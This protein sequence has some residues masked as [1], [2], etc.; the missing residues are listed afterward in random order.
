MSTA[1]SARRSS[2]EPWI[3]QPCSSPKAAARL[4]SRSVAA[5]SLISGCVRMSV[6]YCPAML[7][8]PTIPIPSGFMLERLGH[9]PPGVCRRGGYCGAVRPDQIALQLYTVRGLAATD[10]PGTLRAV[11]DAGYQ[12]V[13]L[14]GLPDIGSTQLAK[15]LRDHGLRP[16]A[17]HQ[18]IDSL[19]GDIDGVAR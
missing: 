13:E 8:V 10:L 19:R 11:A 16:V 18:S 12:A 17:A 14:A 6:A 4:A 3:R 7:P 5:T 15:L 9:M 1:G 2:R